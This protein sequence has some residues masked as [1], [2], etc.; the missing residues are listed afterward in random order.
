MGRIVGVKR[1]LVQA[2][3]EVELMNETESRL[4]KRFK[5]TRELS[6]TL[7]RLNLSLCSSS[8]NQLEITQPINAANTLPL[9]KPYVLKPS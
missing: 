4:K 3:D 1:R 7:E 6:I 9:T 5:V 2:F 8:Q